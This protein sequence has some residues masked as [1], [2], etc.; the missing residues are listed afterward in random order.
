VRERELLEAERERQDEQER[1]QHLRA[2]QQYPQLVEQLDQLAVDAR[3]AILEHVSSR[4]TP[5]AHVRPL[6]VPHP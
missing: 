5:R 6:G 1:E 4:P 3:F 2:G